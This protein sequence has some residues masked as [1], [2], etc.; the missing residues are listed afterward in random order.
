MADLVLS[1]AQNLTSSEFGFVGHIDPQTGYLI[2]STM[3]G[4]IWDVCQVP[5]K[6]KDFVFKENKGLWGWVLDNHQLLMTNKPDMDSRSTGIPPGHVP[7][8]RFLGVPAI[9]NN[10]LLG[11]VAL[12]NPQKDYT[13]DDIE[14]IKKLTGL[15]GLAIQKKHDE[16]ELQ[17]KNERFRELYLTSQRDA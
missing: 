5:E 12:A 10:S 14:V 7:I 6:D 8:Q 16:K 13:N 1:S 3:T 2:S 9:I 15:Y 11:I 4:E 17:V